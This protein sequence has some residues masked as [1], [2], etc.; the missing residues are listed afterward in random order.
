MSCFFIDNKLFHHD[1]IIKLKKNNK[2]KKQKIKKK[3][4]K[5]NE[6]M[7][8]TWIILLTK[9]EIVDEVIKV[10]FDVIESES[11]WKI[12]YDTPPRKKERKFTKFK[13][14]ISQKNIFKFDILIPKNAILQT[15]VVLQSDY[16]PKKQYTMI[17]IKNAD[18]DMQKIVQVYKQYKKKVFRMGL[19]RNLSVLF[20]VNYA[21][22]L[23]MIYRH[24]SSFDKP[25]LQNLISVAT[26]LDNI[27]VDQWI[28]RDINTYTDDNQKIKMATFIK[29]FTDKQNIDIQQ[30]LP[31]I[32]LKQCESL[33]FEKK[34]K[35]TG[36]AYGNIFHASHK[37]NS[38]Q[39]ILK[40][41]Y[42][43]F[44]FRNE[45]RAYLQLHDMDIMPKLY[46]SYICFGK[47]RNVYTMIFE[48][49]D[50]TL[51]EFLLQKQISVEQATD[52]GQQLFSLLKKLHSKEVFHL[53]LH[54]KNIMYRLEPQEKVTLFLIDFGTSITKFEKE[55]IIGVYH[56]MR[57]PAKKKTV[58]FD[59]YFLLL[60][61]FIIYWVSQNYEENKKL[62]SNFAHADQQ[63]RNSFTPTGAVANVPFVFWMRSEIFINQGDEEIGI[64]MYGWEKI[65]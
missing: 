35:I 3:F 37:T 9:N 19:I 62:V 11:L 36:G 56:E 28:Y 5:Q 22:G 47:V 1:F 52:F 13:F 21:A 25:C 46:E 42:S 27:S 41:Q 63:V 64:A 32:P 7:S 34:D 24:Q 33:Y 55:E 39:Y 18:T 60:N 14:Q 53:D 58:E 26:M 23:A 59:Y 51:S 50:G 44:A 6:K 49:L 65:K 20:V 48:K 12:F 54:V 38:E 10:N 16:I 43:C 45:L 31:L 40:E 30:Y 17:N 29:K 15:L 8:S 57:I 61:L 2:K 4:E